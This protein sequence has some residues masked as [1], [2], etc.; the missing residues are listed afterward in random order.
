MA[1]APRHS[2]IRP[3][4]VSTIRVDKEL[5]IFCPL[6]SMLRIGCWLFLLAAAAYGLAENQ[7]GAAADEQSTD[8]LALARA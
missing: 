4:T 6:N 7:K 1:P 8:L 3:A 5:N 2:A